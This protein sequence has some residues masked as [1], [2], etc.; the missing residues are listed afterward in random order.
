L[1]SH[2]L[3]PRKRHSSPTSIS[4]EFPSAYTLRAN[5]HRAGGGSVAATEGQ[6]EPIARGEAGRRESRR[7]RVGAR[8][9]RACSSSDIGSILRKGHGK[10]LASC[11]RRVSVEVQVRK[12]ACRGWNQHVEGPP[13]NIAASRDPYN[14][15]RPR[16][17]A[18][19]GSPG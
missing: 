12:R 18:R 15:V 5:A 8:R 3:D 9:N 16:R 1:N 14:E 13:S 6:R 17:S 19:A 2:R 11:L 10:R 4:P 7:T